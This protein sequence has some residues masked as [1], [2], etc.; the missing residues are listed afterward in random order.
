MAKASSGNVQQQIDTLRE[1]I[2]GHDHRYYVEAQ[3]S[4]SDRDYDKLLDQLKQ[5]EDE[6]PSLITADSPT[7]RVAGQPLA[8]FQTIEH[9]QP[10]YSIDNT[11]DQGELTAWYNRV[12]KGLELSEDDAIGLLAEPKIDG[13]AVS[14]RYQQGQLAQALTRGDGRQGD[15]IT[16]NVRTI[17]AIPLQLITKNTSPVPEVLEVRGEIFMPF[18]EFQRINEKRTAAGEEPFANPRNSTAGTLKMLDSRV[19]GERRLDFIAHGRGEISGDALQSYS[20]F[21]AALRA[22]GLPTNPLTKQCGSLAEV[23]QLIEEFEQSRAELPYGVDGVVIKVDR[24]DQQEQL[25]FTSRFP[26][27]CIAYK[28]AAEQAVTKLLRIDWQVGKTG[29]LT[30]RAIMEP[31][32]VA[33]TTVQHAT[34]HNLGEV[35][36]KDIRVGDTVVIEKAGEIIPQVVQVLVDQRGKGVKPTKAPDK[37]PECQG[38]VEAEQDSSGKET[39]RHCINPE[40]PAQFRERLIHYASRGQMDIEGMGEKVVEQLTA[41][42]LVDTIGQIY[43]LHTRREEVLKL[44]RMGEKKADNLFAGVESS[45][46][47][48]LARV[49]ASLGNRHVGSPTSRI[50]ADHYGSIDKLMAASA[51]E[52]EN[53]EV[54]GEKSGIGPEIAKSLHAFLQSESGRHVI[55][56]LRE[57]G[58]SLD[59][60]QSTKASTGEGILSGKT[61]VVTGT[62]SKYTREEIKQLIITHGG[63]AASSVSKSTDYVVAGE[64]AGSKL[65]KAESLGV[66]V[67]SEEGFEKLIGG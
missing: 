32:L 66:E 41:A 61:L 42:H 13:V 54:A 16:Q 36:R 24:Y 60:P 67:L 43:S 47:R 55:D 39:A 9:A 46:Q 11:Y 25:G 63:K 45:K 8:G 15:D 17:R 64:K 12:V 4:I 49:L 35:L 23:W 58:V 2:R 27:W 48:G 29:K 7:Q 1:Q 30:P 20:E 56:E 10:M 50:I 18:G 57:A 34:L 31:V 53:F 65:A 5:L 37:C 38:D 33:G 52:I 62:M 19:V 44:Q 3:P 22:W 59:M 40:C 21:L 26:R 6:H 28:Y 14:L 51:E